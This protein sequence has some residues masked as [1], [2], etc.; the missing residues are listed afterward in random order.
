ML[1]RILIWSSYETSASIWI[2][3]NLTTTEA[4]WP[5]GLAWECPQNWG[6]HSQKWTKCDPPSQDKIP[7][8]LLNAWAYVR[9][10]LLANSAYFPR[11]SLHIIQ[12]PGIIMIIKIH[13]KT[14]SPKKLDIL[15]SS[16]SCE[17]AA[18]CHISTDLEALIYRLCWCGIAL[19]NLTA[20]Y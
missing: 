13:F 12:K 15:L 7:T 4:T 19:V 6:P 9:M 8:L 1:E 14:L 17:K 11:T 5:W 18:K 2:T 10:M 20:S 3:R 16:F